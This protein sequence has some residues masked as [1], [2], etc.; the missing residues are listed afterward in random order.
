[1]SKKNEKHNHGLIAI[2]KIIDRSIPYLVIALALV[3][4]GDFTL[5]LNKYEP[6]I[7][8]FDW[9]ILIVFLVDLSFKWTHTK[10]VVKFV[11][12]Y[13]IDLLAVFPFY[14]L[15]R[16]INIF[17]EL[18]QFTEQG[19][20]ILHETALLTEGVAIKEGEVIAKE[21]KVVSRTGRIIRTIQRGIR[22]VALRWDLAHSHMYKRSKELKKL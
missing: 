14:L 21:G 1:M 8:Y 4:V 6:W 15:F 17:G 11:K 12:L 13:W 9:F 5:D 16:F 3:I 10:K 22:A 2:E 19:Q 7:T 20:K 18:V